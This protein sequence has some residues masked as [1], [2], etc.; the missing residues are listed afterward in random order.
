MALVQ[1]WVR[2]LKLFVLCN[3]KAKVSVKE[4]QKKYQSKGSKPKTVG[5]CQSLATP[6]PRK[7]RLLLRWSPTGR[8]FNQEGI[9]VDSNESKSKSD[10]SND[11]NACTS[12]VLKPKIKWFL[13]STLCLTGYSDLFM[14][15]RFG[16]F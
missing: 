10:C 16:L 4:I 5:T 8:L 9:L 3:Q 11:D 12:N 6:K 14:V 13:N 1:H 15:R 7:S 2:Y